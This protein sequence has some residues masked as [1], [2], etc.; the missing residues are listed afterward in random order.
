[1]DAL[2]AFLRD[3]FDTGSVTV[4]PVDGAHAC[5]PAGLDSTAPASS[6]LRE[7]AA[8]LSLDMPHIAPDY[9]PEV[10]AWAARTFHEVCRL[11]VWPGREIP[12]DS[13]LRKPAPNLYDAAAC[14]S[15][16]VILQ[17]LPG[18]VAMARRT[19]APEALTGYLLQLSGAW[20]LSSV[21]IPDVPADPRR[22]EPIAAHPS[23][24]TLYSDRVLSR[25]DAS[26]LGPAWLEIRIRDAA[27]AYPHLV[28]AEIRALLGIEL[29]NLPY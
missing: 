19:S 26:R 5:S 17:F 7:Q 25:S 27:G 28:P 9:R 10:A 1:M 24:A 8:A 6:I 23:L 15:A 22:L 14:F 4:D 29:Q 11:L 12:Q 2:A 3:L 16:D 21:G 20:P 18:L 13:P